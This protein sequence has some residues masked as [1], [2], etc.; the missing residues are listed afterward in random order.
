MKEVSPRRIRRLAETDIEP[1]YRNAFEQDRVLLT[2]YWNIL[3]KRRRIIIVLFSVIF[4]SGAYCAL[5]ATRLYTA[6]ATVKIEPQNPQVTG[7]GALQPLEGLRGLEGQY[8]YH[9]T[10]FALL[11]SRHL[12]ARVLTDLGLESNEIF[13][14]S[15]IASPNPFDRVISWFSPI[16]DYVAWVFESNLKSDEPQTIKPIAN[17]TTGEIELD[18]APHLIQRYL[19]F[20]NIAPVTQTR[21]VNVEFTTPDPALSS[22]LAN[23]H[24]QSFMRMNFE[25]RFTLTKEARL[26]LDQKKTELRQ[27]MERSEAALNN[28]RRTHGVVSVDKGENIAVDRLVDLNKQLTGA[29]AQRIAAESL[30]RTV[31]NQKYQDLAE[32]MTQGLVQQLKAN[33]ANLE[34]ENARLGAV[35]K[36]DHPRIEELVKQIAAARQGL[37]NEIGNVVR[38]IQS[39]YEAALAKERALEAET[40]KQQQDALKLK[41]VGVDYT[42]LQEEVNANRSLYENVLK[43][44]TETNVSNDLAV[45]NI[46]IVERAHKPLRPSSP[47]IPLYLL[48][49]MISGAVFGVGIAFLREYFDSTVGTPDNVWR[50]VGLSTLGVVPHVKCLTG[51]TSNGGQSSHAHHRGE[52]SA[53]FKLTYQRS[54]VTDLIMSESPLSIVSESYRTIRTSLLFT[55]PE[56][57]PQV[58]LVTSPSPGEGKTITSLN[59]ATALAHDGYSVL[60][61]DGDMRR[62]SCHTRLG[63][64]HNNG[65]SNVLTGHLALEDG[66]QETSVVG[67]SLF[68]RGISPPNPIELLGSPKMREILQKLRQ[69]FKF[70]LIDSPPVI[71]LSDATVLS[72]MTDGVILVFDGQATS[73]ASAQRAVE[74]LDMVRAHL[75]GVVLNGVNLDNPDYSHYRAYSSYCRSADGHEGIAEDDTDG[76]D[77][78][79]YNFYKRGKIGQFWSRKERAQAKDITEVAA[80]SETI[81]DDRANHGETVTGVRNDG[82]IDEANKSKLVYTGPTYVVKE[83]SANSH[84][85]SDALAKLQEEQRA[86][87]IT[88]EFLRRLIETLTKTIGSTAP[89]LVRDQIGILGES[90]FSFPKKR[91]GEL[92]KL[93]EYE[94]DELKVGHF[95]K[96][97][98]LGDLKRLA[99]SISDDNK[100]LGIK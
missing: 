3:L 30:Y 51:R 49:T 36:P 27:K 66:I 11:K 28:F 44:L 65:L 43:R 22:A 45:S 46:Q 83:P 95:T 24:A 33:V 74:R 8:D 99:A 60:L 97:V 21:L 1:V 93:I 6:S 69:D 67:L 55:Q 56:K 53:R 7:V 37:R 4:A 89:V 72:V 63:L 70:I 12:A 18:V 54:S 62:G 91:I 5:T 94:M 90:E 42:I 61:V 41:E 82:D 19:T 79:G 75:L 9:R 47:N 29:R 40:N 15:L 98:I 73:T 13:T 87:P 32:I 2:D 100:H 20:I 86:A 50:S 35:F 14:T 80:E 78:A 88:Q 16:L 68:S 92:L 39:S 57:P 52:R 31:D 23:A 10:Q 25:N 58:V 64:E 84:R 76:S 17:L 34:A 71:T 96:V 77:K 81:Q 26:F 38:G 59:L 48:V 85:V